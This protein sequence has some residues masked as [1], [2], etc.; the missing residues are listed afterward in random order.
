LW[1]TATGK[2]RLSFSVQEDARVLAFSSDGR[3]LAT[4]HGSGAVRVW[5]A[6][7]GR[8][9]RTCT[10]HV[11]M[12]NGLAFAPDGATLYT[13]G[14]GA[15]RVWDI[16]LAELKGDPGK[17]Q[18]APA[19]ERNPQPGHAGPVGSAAFTPDG[20]VLL[21]LGSDRRLLRWD[22]ITGRLL[23]E[24]KDFPGRIGSTGLV[25]MPDG[26]SILISYLEGT[27][28]FLQ[29]LQP[30]V[31]DLGVVEVPPH[32]GLAGSLVIPRD[33]SAQLLDRL[34]GRGLIGPAWHRQD[35]QP[36]QHACS[37]RPFLSCHDALPQ[38]NRPPGSATRPLLQRTPDPSRLSSARPQR[39]SERK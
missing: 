30:C 22:A 37:H 8:L 18:P 15:V 19:R 13:A 14:D 27:L 2:P 29:F 28:S 35:Q 26:R 10:G 9:V 4:G 12:I 33:P 24:C 6:D 3:F 23:G 1:D 5:H 17:W 11:W 34:H 39:F 36:Q 38:S 21:T 7:S 20:R 31:R 25:M 16:G 32:D